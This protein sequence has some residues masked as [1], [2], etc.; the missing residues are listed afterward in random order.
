M[1]RFLESL[2]K[3]KLTFIKSE[4]KSNTSEIPSQ[5]KAESNQKMV[6]ET[7]TIPF[8][9]SQQLEIFEYQ[10]AVGRNEDES[11]EDLLLQTE[12]LASRPVNL[13]R[14]ADK[15]ETKTQAESESESES[16]GD[17]TSSSFSGEKGYRLENV[18]AP[19][20]LFTLDEQYNDLYE[21]PQ[22][23]KN[24]TDRD[25]EQSLALMSVNNV[26]SYGSV[27]T[28]ID[29][30]QAQTLLNV[31]RLKGAGI[32]FK[33]SDLKQLAIWFKG[34]SSTVKFTARDLVSIA[35]SAILLHDLAVQYAYPDE[36]YGTDLINILTGSAT[37]E[38]SWSSHLGSF[39]QGTITPVAWPII[40]A[41]LPLLF[42]LLAHQINYMLPSSK[43]TRIEQ[44]I[45][46]GQG[47][48][49]EKQAL[50]SEL[51]S[52]VNQGGIKGY[53]S[54]FSLAT[55][56]G[57]FNSKDRQRFTQ[58]SEQKNAL[59]ALN[60]QATKALQQQFGLTA[61][62]LSWRAGT[63]KSRLTQAYWI[64]ALLWVAYALYAN[65][66]YA[67]VFV[68]K[69]MEMLQYLEAQEACEAKDNYY[70]WTDATADYE[71]TVC[72]EWPF[73]SYRQS[74]TADGCMNMLL[75]Q[76]LPPKAIVAF[77]R[78]LGKNRVIRTLD[79]SAQP[80]HIWSKNDLE[81]VLTALQVVCKPGVASIRFSLKDS[82]LPP[83]QLQMRLIAGFINQ[84]QPL[85]VNLSGLQLNEYL[86]AAWLSDTQNYNDIEQLTLSNNPLDYEGVTVIAK[87]LVKFS[88]LKSLN[89]ANT[90]MPNLGLRALSEALSFHPAVLALDIADNHFQ[91]DGLL[92]LTR[93]WRN[94]TLEAVNL[95][96]NAITSETASGLNN[97]FKNR[98]LLKLI[99]GRCEINDEVLLELADG[100]DLMETL[101][102]PNN[103]I[104]DMGLQ[105][106]IS[107]KRLLKL[108]D[109]DISFNQITDDSM[110]MLGQML[111]KNNLTRL[112]LSGNA[113]T[114]DG[115]S[116]LIP[117]L[118]QSRLRAIDIEHMPLADELAFIFAEHFKNKTL[119]IHSLNMGDIGLTNAGAEAVLA[120]K[121]ELLS[122]SLDHNLF[123]DGIRQ[124]LQAFINRNP[125]LTILNMG[126]NLVNGS[127]LNGFA[128]SLA[129]SELSRL[130]L[131]GNALDASSVLDFASSLISLPE[132]T[133][134]DQP[135]LSLDARR[136]L[137]RSKPTTRLTEINMQDL[138]LSQD[139]HRVF[140]RLNTAI[141]IDFQTNNWRM[142]TNAM[143]N[144]PYNFHRALP[145]SGH[146]ASTLA[147]RTALSGLALSPFGMSFII[148]MGIVGIVVLAYLL[149]RATE[150]IVEYCRSDK[151]QQG[152]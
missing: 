99:A 50:L 35:F 28:S 36:R 94:N 27:S 44:E 102:L 1:R 66:R 63:S 65:S 98:P 133:Q 34:L 18:V 13:P 3:Q 17:I 72:P 82:D 145:A 2:K 24:K 16:D 87:G 38:Q 51:I 142:Q 40:F 61:S 60:M 52:R 111:S 71:C 150:K 103:A 117:Y 5:K 123:D 56:A 130:N 10:A 134:L 107:T 58:H 110:G 68:H 109:F 62:Y 8:G 101:I 118:P 113:L 54:L 14:F 79:F 129:A 152:M 143:A 4:K 33:D 12:W 26:I 92:E 19:I 23:E 84:L 112:S 9:N 37:N 83:S 105:Y 75:T 73:V 127:L 46:W 148:A 76:S 15:L 88:N 43:S 100:L 128:G 7:E 122:L 147:A 137:M 49:D 95:S 29:F 55:I 131:N 20:N 121:T 120:L 115:F 57:S 149:Y 22:F 78:Q 25:V 91:E 31:I 97:A 53:F 96:G 132:G 69:V 139:E 119:G 138:P 104:S 70:L 48:F 116:I 108:I 67:T 141:N 30:N 114:P 39:D 89:L 146:S 6:K 47:N 125:Q 45:L 106:F 80:W 86:L 151:P 90:Q 42:P 93:Q 21:V 140:G 136:A 124:G 77:S 59:F 85:H 135:D 41:T 64:P 126:S 32:P 81:E 11:H 74:L 144:N